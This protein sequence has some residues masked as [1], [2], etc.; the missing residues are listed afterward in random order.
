MGFMNINKK[1][2]PLEATCGEIPEPPK[3]Y[4]QTPQQYN[5]AV[6]QQQSQAA[7]DSQ[8]Y[9]TI[10][11]ALDTI[12]QNQIISHQEL[13]D[14]ILEVRLLV[15]RHINT[16]YQLLEVNRIQPLQTKKPATKKQKLQDPGDL[17]DEEIP[18]Y[19]DEFNQ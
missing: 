19:P 7:T 17:E 1:E 13:K 18:G 2:L 10:M 12:N 6:A 3:I 15:L 9:K 11:A 8:E 5:Q 14:L 16:N 4:N